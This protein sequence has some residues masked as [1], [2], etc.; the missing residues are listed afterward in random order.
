[1]IDYFWPQAR[2]RCDSQFR[3]RRRRKSTRCARWADCRAIIAA[4]KGA[5]R[6]AIV[7]GSFIGLEAAAALR[8][9]NLEV[10]VIALEK[11]LMERILGPEMGDFI[12]GLHEEHG[13]IFHLEDTVTAVEGNRVTLKS[14]GTL[15]ADFLLAGIGVRPRLSLAEQAGLTMD[16]GVLVNEYLETSVSNIYAAGDIARWPDPHS[17]GS[18]RVE[19]WAVAER[20]GQTAARNI[21]GQRRKFDAVPFFWSAH[22]DVSIRYIGHAEQWDEIAIEGEIK[23]KDCLLRYRR[24]G[25]TL[26][27]A[28]ICRDLENLEIEARME[29]AVAAR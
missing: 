6:V 20:Q 15:D 17:E 23:A 12:R 9:R 14:G 13:V 27:V 8:A 19:H 3:T 28:S 22:Y 11:R 2:S 10:H 18:I 4:T 21:L 1:M 24:Q 26:A 25:R 29:S 7:G 5:R 16:R